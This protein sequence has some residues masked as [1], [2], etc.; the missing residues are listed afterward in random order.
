MAISEAFSGSETVGT[1]EHSM[2]TDTA[3]P[4]TDT[5]DGI[6]QAFVDFNAVVAGDQFRFRVYE[7]V[8][9]S[10]TQRLVFEAHIG[11]VQTAPNW[12]S[13]S[14]ILMHGWDMTLTKIAG[15]DRAIDWSIRKVA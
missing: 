10:S 5:T 14:L 13:P 12:A 11:G 2:T 15:T 9:S 8:L 6:Y 7:K 3:G 4:D 1:T